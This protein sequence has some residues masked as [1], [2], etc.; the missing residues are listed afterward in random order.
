MRNFS[1]ILR[2][3]RLVCSSWLW[4]VQRSTVHRCLVW[5]GA[6]PVQA[7]RQA[8]QRL[9]G[10]GAGSGGDAVLQVRQRLG[11]R[12]ECGVVPEREVCAP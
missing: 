10:G 8:G 6:P 2:M 3:V 4:V 7:G 1:V 9:G 11:E 12:R 5:P